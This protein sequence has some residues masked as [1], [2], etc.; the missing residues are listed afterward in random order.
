[1]NEFYF[2]LKDSAEAE[3]HCLTFG[4]IQLLLPIYFLIKASNLNNSFKGYFKGYEVKM[5][6][7]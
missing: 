4:R 5:E 6:L 1:M 7:P 3:K 2:M